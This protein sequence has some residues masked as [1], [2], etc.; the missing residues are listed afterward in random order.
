MAVSLRSSFIRQLSQLL[1]GCLANS[2]PL[3][4]CLTQRFSWVAAVTGGILRRRCMWCGLSAA[5]LASLQMIH[6]LTPANGSFLGLSIVTV[7]LFLRIRERARYIADR[8]A[9]HQ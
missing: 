2:H 5:M 6:A 1:P 9:P 7:G 8:A 3:L 4:W